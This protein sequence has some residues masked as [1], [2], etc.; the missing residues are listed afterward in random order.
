ML[1]CS[2]LACFTW[3]SVSSPL[4]QF[5]WFK[6]STRRWTCWFSIRPVWW[7][8][9]EHRSLGNDTVVHGMVEAGRR[10]GKG[11]TFVQGLTSFCRWQGLSAGDQVRN[12]NKHL[13]VLSATDICS[14]VLEAMGSDTKDP[15]WSSVTLTITMGITRFFT[16][17]YFHSSVVSCFGVQV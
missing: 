3:D 9:I 4:L 15:I 1:R 13:P 8:P 12:I 17:Q 7:S 2:G 11:D 5:Q 16:L 6:F 14:L 10:T